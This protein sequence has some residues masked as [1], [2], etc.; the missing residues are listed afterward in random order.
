MK[1]VVSLDERRKAARL[2]AIR[3]DLPPRDT[4]RW[5]ARRKAAVARAVEAG[6]IS[7][8]EA[9]QRYSISE[10]ELRSWCE[11]LSRHG[12]TALATTRLQ[13]YRCADNA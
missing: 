5:V 3:E 8:E 6:A 9:M 4:E 7:A 2:Q 12:V 13:H 1:N 11:S 10:E